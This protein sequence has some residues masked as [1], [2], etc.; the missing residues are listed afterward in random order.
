MLVGVGDDVGVVV[1]VGGVR[2]VL[3]RVVLGNGW[4]RVGVEGGETA[5]E[6]G[7]DA[8]GRVDCARHDDALRMTRRPTLS[9]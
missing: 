1:D 6:V 2:D 7:G 5:A 8:M 3:I 4:E 9:Y